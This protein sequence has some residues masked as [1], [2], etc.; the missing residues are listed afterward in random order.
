MTD[1]DTADQEWHRWIAVACERVGVDPSLVDV[2]GIHALSRDI[3]HDF[4]RPMA[5]VGSFILGLAVGAR[6]ARGEQVRVQE[7]MDAIRATLGGV[8]P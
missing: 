3:A 8:S 2:V 7:L 1:L 5:P 6:A 4:A